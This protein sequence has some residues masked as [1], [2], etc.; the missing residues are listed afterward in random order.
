MGTLMAE[1][2]LLPPDVDAR[3]WRFVEKSDGCWLW[4][5]GRGDDGY[6][7]FKLPGRVSIRAHR[8]SYA[9]AVAEPEGLQVLHRCD[10]PRCVRPDHLFLGTNADNMADRNGKGRYS[11]GEQHRDAKVTADQVREIRRRYAAGGVSQT[12]L[13]REFG[14]SQHSIWQIV[15]NV[16]W[17]E[18][19]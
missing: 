2:R 18:V 4:K 12:A 13:G 3:F 11:H 1:R 9:I 15:R 8:L 19:A 14:L 6:G 10:V 17:K 7:I 5:G 16:T